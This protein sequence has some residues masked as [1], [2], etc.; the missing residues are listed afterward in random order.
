MNTRAVIAIFKRNLFSYFG[1]PTGYVFICAFVLS[2]GFAAFWPREFFNANLA[3]LDQLNKYIHFILLGFV[4][5]ITMGIWA[6]ERRQGTD[7]LLLTLPASDLQ[8]VLG[9][10]I[11]AVAIFTISL[12]FSLTNLFVLNWLGNPDM[13]LMFST[14][15]GYWFMGLSMLAVGMVASFLTGN[16]TV[17]FVLGV[18]FNAPLV[19]AGHADMLL[20]SAAMTDTMRVWS[21]HA[22]FYDFARGIISLSGIVY[23]SAIIGVMLYLCSVLIGRR[24][25]GGTVGT[26]PLWI[27]YAARTMSLIIAT[28]S[29]AA[30]VNTNDSRADFSSEK[31]SVLSPKSIELLKN[32]P[33]DRVIKVEAFI[34]PERDIPEDYI[35]TR[36]NLLNMLDEIERR[37]DGRIKITRHTDVESFMPIATMAEERYGITEQQMLGSQQGSRKE[38]RFYMALAFVGG[39]NKQVIVPFLQRGIPVEYELM[40][41]IVSL[42]DQEKKTLGV[43]MDSDSQMV[44]MGGFDPRSRQPMPINQLITELRKQYN[45]KAVD[46]SQAI[47][48]YEQRDIN[49]NESGLTEPQKAQAEFEAI[50]WVKPRA[51]PGLKPAGDYIKESQWVSKKILIA[52]LQSL[53]KADEGLV[54]LGDANATTR[55]QKILEQA[56]KIQDEL[57][58]AFENVKNKAEARDAT[59]IFHLARMHEK[60]WGCDINA[61][62]AKKYYIEAANLLAGTSNNADLLM[63]VGAAF[64]S[65]LAVMQDMSAADRWYTKAVIEY[66]ATA[67]DGATDAM[68]RLG[69]LCLSNKGLPADLLR[70]LSAHGSVSPLIGISGPDPRMRVVIDWYSKAAKKDDP[71]GASKMAKLYEGGS[72]LPK[73]DAKAAEWRREAINLYLARANNGDAA[74]QHDLGVIYQQGYG[75]AP[76]SK[77]AAIWFAKA[78]AT[79][80]AAA[81]KGKTEAQFEL[82]KMLQF[83][84][85]P[86]HDPA[87][88]LKWFSKAAESGHSGSMFKMGQMLALGDADLKNLKTAATWYQKAAGKGN[89]QAQWALADMYG[90]GDGLK[91]NSIAALKW[92]AIANDLFEHKLLVDL[93]DRIE[94]AA[95]KGK[96]LAKN[97][98]A[99]LVFQPSAMSPGSMTNLIEAIET[100]APSAILEDPLVALYQRRDLIPS[101]GDPKMGAPPRMPGM[102]PQP[103]PKADINQLWELL[104]IGNLSS[105]DESDRKRVEIEEELWSLASGSVPAEANQRE[106]IGRFI[107]SNPG[108]F[109]AFLGEAQQ[110]IQLKVRKEEST[111]SKMKEEVDRR[112]SRDEIQLWALEIQTQLLI[113]RINGMA[114]NPLLKGAFGGLLKLMQPLLIAQELKVERAAVQRKV[115]RFDDHSHRTRDTHIVYHTYNPF[116]KNDYLDDEIVFAGGTA[117]GDKTA[118]RSDHEISSGLQYLLFPFTGSIQQEANATLAFDP[119]VRTGPISGLT[120]SR[121]MT[122]SQGG[123]DSARERTSTSG[124]QHILAAHIHGA[125]TISRPKGSAATTDLVGRLGD[126]LELREK[127][128]TMIEELSKIDT[129]AALALGKWMGNAFWPEE[130]SQGKLS[131]QMSD[132][133]RTAKQF[134]TLLESVDPTKSTK[135]SALLNQTNGNTFLTEDLESIAPLLSA[136]VNLFAQELKTVNAL[137]FSDWN[138]EQF[139]NQIDQE[140]GKLKTNSPEDNGTTE[141]NSTGSIDADK[142]IDDL[143]ISVASLE[144]TLSGKFTA[145]QLKTSLSRDRFQAI[146]NRRIRAQLREII[147]ETIAILPQKLEARPP[148]EALEQLAR[149]RAMENELKNILNANPSELSANI[150]ALRNTAGSLA[151]LL[152]NHGEAIALA[153]KRAK[154]KETAGGSRMPEPKTGKAAPWAADYTT[155]DAFSPRVNVVLASDIDFVARPLFQIRGDGVGTEMGMNMDVDNVT[156]ILNTLDYLAK[157]DRYISIRN[158]RRVHRT[159][160]LIEKRVREGRQQIQAK[161]EEFKEQSRAV[162]TKAKREFQEAMDKLL[163]E[164]DWHSFARAE[165]E[166]EE[167]GGFLILDLNERDEYDNYLNTKKILEKQRDDYVEREENQMKGKRDKAIKSE[168]TK[169]DLDIRARE[170]EIKQL[171]VFLPPIIPLALGIFIFFYQL[172]RETIGVRSSRIR[173][174]N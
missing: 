149:L 99:L 63:Q 52:E 158:K 156:F 100:G 98:D 25:W 160:S 168:Q 122:G 42:L 101:T 3:N 48:Q 24:H 60:G 174:V 90:K 95:Q 121:T 89:I 23:F 94:V 37:A 169:L 172:S 26:V 118:F 44:L 108:V 6:D 20:I 83:G 167:A 51:L 135:Y 53:A 19:M 32:I 132:L 153:L 46:P 91:R 72:G 71:V 145:S 16:L 138:K 39:E 18:A 106:Q 75:I 54:K 146:A 96:V 92:N 8:V 41:S 129:T 74:A 141:G 14:Y 33:E 43:V 144:G 137:H 170:T 36:I 12:F 64:E 104:Q 93:E 45:V 34:S 86:Q 55:Q 125:P 84:P 77:S 161:R 4:P 103:A 66:N 78:L 7:E 62:A 133:R 2:S 17:A 11:A 150:T 139:W 27:H 116:P 117:G 79:R 13:G 164:N 69:D 61:T 165:A 38:Y 155:M 80:M 152:D 29:L 82:G 111:R 151:D 157:D 65:G 56:A 114:D 115:R 15:L 49:I 140:S 10:Y 21:L 173:D 136:E 1:S 123:L 81:E 134:S 85:G 5:A 47:P 107:Q 127:Q 166:A 67:N 126:G 73:N 131:R 76:S 147:K 105:K 35:Q 68:I 143:H 128:A 58:A 87:S 112:I 171:A 88:A 148:R 154:R 142:I 120:R 50:E 59:S 30:I 57:K 109:R 113:N 31:L 130:I 124:T 102:P 97:Y 22:H 110:R 163:E 70:E 119:L 159:L 28:V 40:R 9:K 162:S